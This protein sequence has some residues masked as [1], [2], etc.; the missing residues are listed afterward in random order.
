MPRCSSTGP[1]CKPSLRAH[2]YA[3]LYALTAVIYQTFSTS[4][5][6]LLLFVGDVTI[7]RYERHSGVEKQ[8]L[9]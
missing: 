9:T 8:S 1:G 5:Y 3:E 2:V 6:Y 4:E 7:Y